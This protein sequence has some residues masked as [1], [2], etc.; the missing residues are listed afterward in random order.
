MR[1]IRGVI[2][3][4]LCVL[5][6]VACSNQ[7]Q[8]GSDACV[9]Q[10]EQTKSYC[11]KVEAEKEELY[12]AQRCSLCKELVAQEKV[13]GEIVSDQKEISTA[14]QKVEKGGVV[15]FKKGSYIQ[16]SVLKALEDVTFYAENGTLI[17]KI[18]FKSENGCKNV[19]IDNFEFVSDSNGAGVIFSCNM[20]G[21]TIKNSSFEGYSRIANSDGLDFAIKNLT[22]TDCKFNNIKRQ[23]KLT[24]IRV[25][26]LENFSL[27]NSNFDGVEY[28]AVQI[29]GKELSGKVEIV[30]NTFKNI[31]QR[32]IRLANNKSTSCEIKGNTF[33]DN[34]DCENT[35]GVYIHCGGGKCTLGANTWETM[36]LFN[37]QEF[38]G[39][40]EDLLVYNATEQK[41]LG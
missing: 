14:I 1:K 9:H 30:G 12:T 38:L 26:L 29:G 32:V 23:N 27:I 22:V 4:V 19:T 20:D 7:N 37:E 40:D 34:N 41:L 18:E 35:D 10:L 25:T 13:S 28:N 8:G 33:Y 16:A 11:V 39:I 6:F 3:A 15:F 21:I 24:A 31:E 2:L 36:P 5:S 17:H